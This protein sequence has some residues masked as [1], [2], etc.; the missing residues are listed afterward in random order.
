MSRRCE[1]CGKG[2]LSGNRVSKSY[3]HTRRTWKPNIVEVKTE[4]GGTT[5]TIKMCT[6]C[7]RSG[8]VTKKV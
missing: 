7:L 4:I 5:M 3:N 2:A 8:Y 6:R 1:I